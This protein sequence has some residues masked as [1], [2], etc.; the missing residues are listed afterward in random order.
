MSK[1]GNRNDY[2]DLLRGVAALGIVAIH[3]AFWSGQS[4][5]PEWFC[6]LT[7]LLDVPFFFF[8][9]GWASGY[10]APNVAKTVKSVGRTWGQW[11]FFILL[12]EL[13]ILFLGL[14]GINIEGV[15]GIKDF[16][17]NAYFDVSFN[18][19]PVILGSIWFM[20]VFFVVLIVSSIVLQL[21]YVD[22]EGYKKRIGIFLIVSALLFVAFYYGKP[23]LKI[24]L[25]QYAFY[26]VFWLVGY[27]YYF[28]SS[29]EFDLTKLLIAIV[30]LFSL[31]ILFTFIQ[32]LPVYDIQSAKFPPSPKYAFVSLICIAVAVFCKKFYKGGGE[33]FKHI[34]RNAIF[35]YF[36]QGVSSSVLF[37]LVDAFDIRFWILKWLLMLAANI[38]MTVA[39]AET[40]S[41]IY[42]KVTY[43]IMK[44]YNR[45]RHGKT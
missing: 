22:G 10:R 14:F 29:K 18:G 24:D 26:C 8:L 28:Y 41:F 30:A 33:I 36:A 35:Y 25:S 42:K 12:L 6:N 21:L 32:D 44:V 4:Y 31:V 27:L 19:L 15:S 7:L 37:Y 11:I 34:G 2:I 43:L 39:I 23:L 9:S 17:S 5:T 38:V 45:K 13:C 1:T 3:T 20:P 40:V 16:V